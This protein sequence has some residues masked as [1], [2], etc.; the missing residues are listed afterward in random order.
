MYCQNCGEKMENGACPKCGTV[1]RQE[2][3]RNVGSKSKIAA[4]V[5][6]ILLGSFGIHNFYLGYN[7]KAV[8]QLLITLLSCFIFSF[9]S[10]IWG[11]IEGIL[12]LTGSIAVDGYGNR[13]VD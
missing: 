10:A 12:I 1:I 6:A 11:I 5:L 13:L 7:G 4:G 9:V 8:V 3:P 2:I